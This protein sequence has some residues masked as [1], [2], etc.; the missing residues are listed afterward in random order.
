M[1]LRAMPSPT[2]PAIIAF[3][4]LVSL[5]ILVLVVDR[6]VSKPGFSNK[7]LPSSRVH[8]ARSEESME[9][10]WQTLFGWGVIGSVGLLLIGIGFAVMSMTPPEFTIA[11][12][13]FSLAAVILVS[14]TAFWLA[15]LAAE[16]TERVIAAFLIFGLIGAAWIWS[17]S[18][19]SSHKPTPPPAAQSLK[20]DEKPPT[21]LDFFLTRGF[22]N[23]LRA[24]D[25]D[26]SNPSIS[27]SWKDN[28]TAR[29]IAQEYLD[30]PA[31]TKFVRFYVM[32]PSV[33]D[34][35]GDK[36]FHACLTLAV[37]D[38]T[39]KMNAIEFAFDRF[40]KNVGLMG[41][42]I[43]QMNTAAQLTFSGRVL[44]YHDDDLSIL[45]KADIIKAFS[46]KNFDVQFMRPEY[47]HAQLV[48]WHKEHGNLKP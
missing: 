27:I 30:F 2:T 23:T 41:G 36:T 43:G 5:G 24:H 44:I 9:G 35:L 7:K 3:F 16:R 38:P 46:A 21:L 14:K 31:K 40:S 39:T 1:A 48:A 20:D 26:V 29:V 8:L 25:Q 6:M 32:R 37:T 42:Q 13:C 19:V 47:L 4:V 11:R 12:V 15:G 34:M 22:N 33:M 18:W 17:Y 45:Q 28:S 10:I